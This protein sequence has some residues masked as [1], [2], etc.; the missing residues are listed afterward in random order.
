MSI[1]VTLKDIVTAAEALRELKTLRIRGKAGYDAAKLVRLCETELET[2]EEQRKKSIRAHGEFDPA[3]GGYK[4]TAESAQ[5]A[6]NKEVEELLAV[7][8][9][10]QVSPIKAAAVEELNPSVGFYSGLHW[11]ITDMEG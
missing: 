1:K 9:E 11:A 10:L 8:I 5:N 7:E 2:F 4:F 3:T 6:L